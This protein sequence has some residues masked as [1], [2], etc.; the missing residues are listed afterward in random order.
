MF[1]ILFKFPDFIPLLGGHA[2]HTYGALVA[3]AFIVGSLYIRRESK[4]VGLNV[5]Q[6]MDLTFYA[7]L[8][9]LIG[10]RIL[11]VI[12][13]IDE[14]WKNPVVFLEFW[15]GG[16]V[17]YGGLIGAAVTVVWYTKKK[18]LPFFK[19]ADVFAVATTLGH[20]IGRLGCFSAGCCY[21]KIAPL[22]SA[23]AVVFKHSEYAL[24]A[25]GHPPYDVPRYPVQIFESVGAFLIFLFL[26]FFRKK[27]K[28][29][30]EVF[31]LYI[32]IYPLLR[33][34]MEIFRG[35]I[36]RKFLIEN[37]LSTSQFISMI[38]FVIAVVLWIKLRRQMLA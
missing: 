11:Y 21:G 5:I 4:R 26:F 34:V 19:V 7:A 2:L 33:F 22:D 9:G 25:S 35:D 32:T 17:F 6:M 1:P 27:K 29:D 24:S 3:L 38:W 15:E 20:S 36:N 18:K 30:G 13:S 8:A 10:S 31:L 16:L 28:F 14:W 23:L 37:V 12:I